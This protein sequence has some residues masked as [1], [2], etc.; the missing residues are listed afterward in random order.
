MGLFFKIMLCFQTYYF[1][2]YC[3]WFRHQKNIPNFKEKTSLRIINVNAIREIW[4]IISKLIIGAQRQRVALAR[5]LIVEPK[6]LLLDEAFAVLDGKIR[7][8]LR[9]WLRKLRNQNFVTIVFVTNDHSEAMELA[10]EIAV[11]EN[12]KIS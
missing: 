6:L 3:I 10:Q 7:K 1:L 8:Q 5:T 2:K 11:L 4:R 9:S 12:G